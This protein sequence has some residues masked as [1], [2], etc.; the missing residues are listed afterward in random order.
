MAAPGAASV[1]VLEL[2][3]TALTLTFGA[4]NHI[5][6]ALHARVMAARDA[7]PRLPGITDVVPAYRSLTV[8]FDPR[9]L[10]RADLAQQLRAAA[11]ALQK[12]ALAGRHWR[13]P[14]CFD[15][16]LGPDLAAVA[17]ATGRSPDAVVAALCAQP[18]RVFLIGFLP[19]FPYMSELPE[20]LRLP[21]LATPRTAVPAR[22]VAIA[23]AQ[24]AIY[25]WQSPGG[26]HLLGSTPARLF[27]ANNVERPALLTPGDAVSF[28][29]IERHEFDR[30][31]AAITAGELAST[32]F[33]T[34]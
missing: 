4:C 32:R 18:W 1:R 7:L 17:A 30:L 15:G 12:S 14:V 29:A 33:A 28:R 19:G 11:D 22:S 13:I 5:D 23:G 16:A 2:G 6:A 3:D 25:P 27:D 24:C 10:S 31:E 8:H 26:W 20:W 9:R 21:R 34:A